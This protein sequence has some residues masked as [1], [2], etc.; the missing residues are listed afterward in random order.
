MFTSG[1]SWIS[2][3]RFIRLLAWFT[4]SESSGVGSA[5]CNTSF[6]VLMRLSLPLSWHNLAAPLLALQAGQVC[7]IMSAFVVYQVSIQEWQPINWPQHVATMAGK[8]VDLRQILH[9]KASLN[10]CL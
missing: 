8:V 10:G 7:F 2:W 4:T 1:K 6:P 3:L 9:R 5:S